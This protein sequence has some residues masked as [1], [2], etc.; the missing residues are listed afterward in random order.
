MVSI[1]TLLFNFVFIGCLLQCNVICCLAANN[2]TSVDCNSDERIPLHLLNV[3]PFPDSELSGWDKGYEL[4]PAAELAADQINNSSD[5]LPGYQLKVVAV[6]SEPCGASSTFTGFVNTLEEILDPKQSLNVVGLTG[7]FC[8]SVTDIIAPITNLSFIQVAASTTHIHRDIDRFPWLF[9]IISASIIFNDVVLEMMRKYMWQKIAIIHSSDGV[10]FTET[11]AEFKKRI[12]SSSEFNLTA[13]IPVTKPFIS[14]VVPVLVS[15]GS[16]I[17]YLIVSLEE[18]VNFMCNAYKRKALYPGY[19]YIFHARTISDFVSNAENASCTKKEMIKALEGVFILDYNLTSDRETKLVSNH[20]YEEYYDEYIDR[21]EAIKPEMNVSLEK[22]NIY[23]NSMYDIIWTFALALNASLKDI[24]AQNISLGNLSWQEYRLLAE[25]LKGNIELV[26]FE[27][28]SGLV[29]FNMTNREGETNVNIFQIMNGSRKLVAIFDPHADANN[30]F[31]VIMQV[32]PPSDSFETRVRLIPFWLTVIFFVTSILCL[33]FTS[34]VLLL[35]IIFHKRPEIKA[36]SPV[37]NITIFIG[38][39]IIIVVGYIQTVLRGYEID[40]HTVYTLLCNLQVWLENIG[41]NLIFSTLLIRLLRINRIF[42]AYNKTSKYWKNQY[43]ILWVLVICFGGVII[44]L[45]WTVFHAPKKTTSLEYHPKGMPPYFESTSICTSSN[46]EIWVFLSYLY[47]TIIMAIVVFLAFQT[48]KVKLTNFKD[49]KKINAYIFVTVLTLSVLFPLSHIYRTD[50]FYGHVFL[51]MTI[52]LVGIY[53]QIFIFVPQV[54][55]T[56][57]N[58]VKEKIN[59]ET[60][61]LSR[62]ETQFVVSYHS[63]VTS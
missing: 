30:T 50:Y 44:D 59:G 26:S 49:T 8:S 52:I 10:L 62:K 15:S 58:I 5:Y 31:S 23:A 12:L 45:L 9:R 3:L 33:I 14:D 29:K 41:L 61:P 40:N 43:L 56:L 54:C 39:Y 20:T 42:K 7:L 13:V 1:I 63:H 32:N 47:S 11:A 37:L 28:A 16:R 51:F 35:I 22:D 53:C 60:V 34:V 2:S 18:A 55:V 48:R 6:K 21:L 19:V 38:C 4:I 27:G 24:H 25:T 46:S 17:I 57:H 36:S